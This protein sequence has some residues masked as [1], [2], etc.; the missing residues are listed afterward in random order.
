MRMQGYLAVVLAASLLGGVARGHGGDAPEDVLGG[1]RV[2]VPVAKKTLVQRGSD[3]KLVL[4]ERQPA[5]AALDLIN[6]DAKAK[7][8]TQAVLLERSKAMDS[9]IQDNLLEVAAAANAFQSGQAVEGL[10]QL[11]ILRGKSPALRGR[12]KL[13][14]QLAAVLP[15]AQGD[16]LKALVKEYWDAI[17]QEGAEQGEREMK[18]EMEAG[19]GKGGDE[20]MGEA[21]QVR[22]PGAVRRGLARAGGTGGAVA[23]EALRLLGQDV[24]AAYER[25]ILRQAAD[26]EEILKRLNLQ[27]QQEAKVRRHIDEAL[28]EAASKGLSESSKKAAR[29]KAFM[30]IWMEL[31]ADQKQELMKV[32]RERGDI[33]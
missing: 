16:E 10:R 20:M 6:L 24:K 15:R 32:L 25:T 14:D 21:P 28:S 4:L 18:A 13:A 5:E 11:A 31:D 9:F 23:R 1:P 2:A 12:E 33:K 30:K 27:P 8:K 3:G 7:E 19:P 26:L 17:A 29:T 22:E